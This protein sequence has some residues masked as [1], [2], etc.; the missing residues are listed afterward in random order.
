MWSFVPVVRFPPIVP[1]NVLPGAYVLVCRFPSVIM[2]GAMEKAGKSA[3]IEG[4]LIGGNLFVERIAF[5]C[6]LFQ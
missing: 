6:C 2:G 4:S 1:N 5:G 3:F